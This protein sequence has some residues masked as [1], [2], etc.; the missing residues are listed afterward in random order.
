MTTKSLTGRQ[1]RWWEKLSGYNLN[2]VYRAGKKNPADAPS[3][4]RDYVKAL[5]GLCMAT[6]L[7]ARCNATF[8]L[9]QLCAAAVQEDQVF[10]DVP[11]DSLLGL[12][13]EGVAEDY[14][15]KKARTA[16]GLPCGFLANEHSLPATL[17]CLYQSHW[18]QHNSLLYYCMQLYIPTA[19]EGCT[20]IFRRHHDDPIAGHFDAKRMLELVSRKYYWPGMGC[21]VKAYAR[22]CSTC[23]RVCRVWHRPHGSME[24][25]PQPRGPWTDI[26]MDFVV[27]LPESRRKRYAKPYNAILVIVNQYTKQACYFPSCDLLDATGLAEILSRKPVLRGA[28]VPQ[29]IVS[30]RGPQFMSKLWAA[31]CYHLG[32]K[33]RLSTAYYQ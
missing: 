26:S 29:C 1:A 12:I 20:E 30:D 2:K 18:Q 33:R 7:T 19:S 21:K 8:R 25:L 16:L 13:C 27:G 32:I 10:K 28:G 11:P 17:L 3:R 15:A 6:V 22:A 14:T 5:E 31:F 9:W 24:P 23:Q 4:Q